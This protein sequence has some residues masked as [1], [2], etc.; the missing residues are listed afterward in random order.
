[1]TTPPQ[2]PP[3]SAQDVDAIADGEI[4]EHIPL[5]LATLGI[6]LA[7]LGIGI[8][9]WIPS[10]YYLAYV[11]LPLALILFLIDAL[12]TLGSK[13][14]GEQAFLGVLFSFAGVVLCCLQLLLD[15]SHPWVS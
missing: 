14:Q 10:L 13:A 1:M 15:S 3:P 12:L 9:T 4:V 6:G 7:G 5:P 2:D 11:S 8:A